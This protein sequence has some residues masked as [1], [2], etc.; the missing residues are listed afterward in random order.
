MPVYIT[1]TP[2]LDEQL[3]ALA[4]EHQEAVWALLERQNAEMQ[5]RLATPPRKRSTQP[6]APTVAES[7]LT[8][9]AQLWHLHRADLTRKGKAR[10]IVCARCQAI[11]YFTHIGY[12]PGQISRVL[13]I[14]RSSVTHQLPMHRLRMSGQLTAMSHPDYAARY[15][16]LLSRLQPEPY[17]ALSFKKPA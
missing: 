2:T 13:P 5:Q 16:A 7:V 11:A 14:E 6:I 8:T 3:A 1:P 17:A 10:E 9:L 15:H 4:P 12:T